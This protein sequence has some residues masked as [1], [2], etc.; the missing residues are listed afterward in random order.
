MR[1]DTLRDG[2][3]SLLELKAQ[4]K[5]FAGNMMAGAAMG[6]AAAVI[7]IG[8]IPGEPPMKNCKDDTPCSPGQ[9][10]AMQLCKVRGAVGAAGCALL[11]P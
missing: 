8:M 5:G 1:T 7:L 10:S 9:G 6:V 2:V 4:Q 3:V 11:I